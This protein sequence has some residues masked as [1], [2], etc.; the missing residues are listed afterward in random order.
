MPRADSYAC[1]FALAFSLIVTLSVLGSASALARPPH[2]VPFDT[3]RQLEIEPVRATAAHAP[4]LPPSVRAALKRIGGSRAVRVAQGVRAG[5]H[6]AL[7]PM[8]W[9]TRDHTGA[10]F[11]L[12]G[13]F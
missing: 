8:F 10:M 1:R 3:P 12:G 5:K 13:L 4:T 9:V 11:A 7:R 6:V 2:I